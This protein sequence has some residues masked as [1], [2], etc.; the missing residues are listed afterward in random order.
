VTAGAAVQGPELRTVFGRDY[1]NAGGTFSGVIPA[2]DQAA[3]VNDDG[4]LTDAE[5]ANRATGLNARFEYESR[6]F[7]PFYG[8]MRFVTNP[9]DPNVR[10][11]AADY[12]VRLLS[13][14]PLA[15]GVFV[16]NA[17]GRV[18][19]PGVS[20]LEPTNTFSLDSGS[21]MGAIS[22]AIQPKWVLANTAGG[23]EDASGI[24]ANAV[25]VFEEFLLRPMESNWSEVGDAVNLINSRLAPGGAPYLVIDTHPSG[26]SS[27]D[28][29]TQTAA[30]AYYYLVADPERTF[31][32]FFGGNN[33]S[34]TW[35]QHWTPAA[36]VDVGVPEGA[37]RVLATGTDPL[38]PSLTYKV[39]ARDYQNALVLYKPL[40]YKSGIGEG[41]RNEQ[42][43]TTH[44][45]GENY[46]R[47]NADGTLGTVISSI[48]LR[49]GE[50][51]V[52]IKA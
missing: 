7:Y 43:G 33:P 45:L 38:S 36:A 3:D 50:G 44:Q 26:G 13:G 24:A 2:F 17:T 16:D 15:D 41:T 30:L 5:Y 48:R 27:T 19:F 25:G 46:R 10:R 29:R 40:S 35:T 49:N 12:H 8:Q 28:A 4:Y 52:L 42:T 11:W 18:P 23:R 1:V 51:A 31:L 21:L 6:L 47:V 22:R 34:S 32:M 20:V 39:F 14:N 37:M 9:S